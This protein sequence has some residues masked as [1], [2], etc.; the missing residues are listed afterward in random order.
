MNVLTQNPVIAN[1]SGTQSLE[2]TKGNTK[3]QIKFFFEPSLESVL[4]IFENQI[5]G[6]L[7]RQTLHESEL[8]HVT[9]RMQQME[10]ALENIEISQKKLNKQKK[11]V[12]K[13]QESAKRLQRLAGISLWR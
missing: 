10:L 8:S 5:F 7:F 12:I 13:R 3:K 4:T 2:A 1:V 6:S 11:L 9:S